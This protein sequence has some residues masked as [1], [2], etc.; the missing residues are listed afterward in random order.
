M[1]V[2][3]ERLGLFLVLNADINEEKNYHCVLVIVIYFIDF[4]F[5]RIIMTFTVK[6]KKSMKAR[7]RLTNL[8][9]L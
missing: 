7:L 9:K 4:V 5:N 6:T 1:I 8:R 2:E 3:P